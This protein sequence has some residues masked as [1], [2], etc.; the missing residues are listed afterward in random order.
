MWRK[1]V[2]V[3]EAVGAFGG[4]SV[5]IVGKLETVTLLSLYA[6]VWMRS[7]GRGPNESCQ[8]ALLRAPLHLINFEGQCA[9]I[10]LLPCELPCLLEKAVELDAIVS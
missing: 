7:Y 6:V 8:L 1:I 9:G 4:L 5:Y 2:E 3:T 10:E